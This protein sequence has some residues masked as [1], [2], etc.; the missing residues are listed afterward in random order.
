MPSASQCLSGPWNTGL[1]TCLLSVSSGITLDVPELRFK[2]LE[3]LN[4]WN[5]HFGIDISG[6]FHLYIISY[7]ILRNLN[8]L[9]GSSSKDHETH[10]SVQD[11]FTLVE[12][13][14]CSCIDKRLPGAGKRISQCL[15][16]PRTTS[17]KQ[18]TD[19]ENS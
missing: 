19:S 18:V 9:T 1:H 12:L 3:E 14:V 15:L 6:I 10:L 4:S 8:L 11:Q 17:D 2:L 16:I 5:Q 13:A 7:F